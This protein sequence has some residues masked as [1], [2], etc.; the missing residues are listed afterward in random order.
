MVVHLSE[1]TQL[2]ESSIKKVK[3]LVVCLI[4]TPILHR[5]V[6]VTALTNIHIIL[7]QNNLERSSA[8]YGAVRQS[9]AIYSFTTARYKTTTHRIDFQGNETRWVVQIL[10]LC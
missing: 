6:K 10:D 1:F 9:E 5:R 8:K 7:I 2:V 4:H 3:V